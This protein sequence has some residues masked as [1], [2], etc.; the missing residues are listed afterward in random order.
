MH[1]ARSG[2]AGPFAAAHN[3]RKFDL[4]HARHID[5]A[6][7][8]LN[9]NIHWA[10]DDHPE[11]SFE[12]AESLFYGRTFSRALDKQNERH[13]RAGNLDR[14]K[15]M[16]DYR[17]SKRTCPE[18]SIVMIGCKG[19]T[20]DPDV[21]MSAWAEQVAWE[22]ERYPKV[23]MLDAAMH[24]DEQGAPHIHVRRAWV[25]DGPDGPT[26]NQ[27][28]ALEQMGVQRPDPGEKAGRHN[29]AK[30]T[31]TAACRAHWLEVCK[32]RG[33]EIEELPAEPG[34]RSLDMTTYQASKEREKLEDAKKQL[35]DVNDE[36][37]GKRTKAKEMTEKANA[38]EERLN[39]FLT[40]EE[41]AKGELVA[42]RAEIARERREEDEARAKREAKEKREAADAVARAKEAIDEYW[43]RRLV[44]QPEA[45]M[46]KAGA[47]ATDERTGR[48]PGSAWQ[49]MVARG[50]QAQ[51]K[52]EAWR[53]ATAG[54][55]GDLSD[56]GAPARSTEFPSFG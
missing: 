28:L 3:D 35:E 54:L 56:R 50:R 21:L 34:K 9:V 32:S 4:S 24:L 23:R 41:Q 16:D 33:L 30:Q 43:R 27:R 19:D 40:S 48:E 7:T 52:A 17:R 10:S 15:T 36:L 38:A 31:Y 13:R 8:H 20:V 45:S 18:E 29:N 12:D 53:K 14:V 5:A 37:E 1:N 26:A 11:M 55:D 2:K 42:L 47:D 44:E 6:K 51:Q 46:A 25:A 22:A 49:T 39:G